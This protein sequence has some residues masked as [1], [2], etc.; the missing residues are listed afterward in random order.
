MDGLRAALARGGDDA[1]NAQVAL[2]RGRGA[3]QV[4]LVGQAHVQSFHVGLRVDGHRRDVHLA[5]RA[6]DPH[7]DLA[8]VG[9]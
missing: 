2:D 7:G 1:V 5:A 3:E 9:Y 8:A 6:H 4:R